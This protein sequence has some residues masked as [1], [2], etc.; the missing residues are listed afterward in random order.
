MALVQPSEPPKAGKTRKTPPRMR[1]GKT[2]ISAPPASAPCVLKGVFF[3]SVAEL[4]P[5]CGGH[6]AEGPGAWW[7]SIP[8]Q[9]SPGHRHRGNRGLQLPEVVGTSSGVGVC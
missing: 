3:P 7:P 5:Q 2:P 6:E 4:K 1:G 8:P 9:P